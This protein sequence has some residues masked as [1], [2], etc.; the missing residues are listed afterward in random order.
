MVVLPAAQHHRPAVSCWRV[1]FETGRVRLAPDCQSP[2]YS[3]PWKTG[4]GLQTLSNRQSVPDTQSLWAQTRDSRYTTKVPQT[5]SLCQMILTPSHRQIASH[6]WSLSEYSRHCQILPL[7]QFF[8]GVGYKLLMLRFSQRSPNTQVPK[9]ASQW[10]SDHTSRSVILKLNFSPI[11]NFEN[12][13][14][15]RPGAIKKCQSQRERKFT[16]T[17]SHRKSYKYP[18]TSFNIQYHARSPHV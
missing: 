7:I 5:P 10:Q 11:L 9:K 14:F 16:N 12:F 6:T 8:M 15:H 3:P 18:V 2:I 1:Q 13:Q 4:K 17:Y